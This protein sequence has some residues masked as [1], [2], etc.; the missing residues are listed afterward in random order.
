MQSDEELL[1][2]TA[3]GDDAAFAAFYR[4]HLDP[5]IAYL[6]RRVATPEQ[7]FDLA[8][9]AFAIVALEAPRFRGEGSATAWLYGIARNLLRES[10][11]RG[12]I[13]AGGRRRLG[14]E[15]TTLD[16]EDLL[17]VEERAAVGDAALEAALAALPEPTPRARP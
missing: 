7:A 3:R 16:D 17:A 13:E 1:A 8:A 12:R 10:L 11:R 6:R 15:P 9:E 2:R 5:V 4:R 14:V